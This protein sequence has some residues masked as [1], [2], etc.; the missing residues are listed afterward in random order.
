MGHAAAVVTSESQYMHL[1]AALGRPHVAIYGAGSPR[2]H[3]V[4]DTR[5]SVMWLNLE[6][7]PCLESHCRFGHMKCL[8]Q[9]L[10]AQVFT[11]LRKAMRFSATA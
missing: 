6:C 7:S 1:A 10:P 3:R 5:R 2:G 4:A 9:Q 8:S 11:S